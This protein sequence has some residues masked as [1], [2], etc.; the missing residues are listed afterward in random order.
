M[1]FFLRRGYAPPPLL[2]EIEVGRRIKLNESGVPAE[3]YVSKHDYESGLN[4]LGRTLLVR[5]N[6]PK[7]GLY[8][9][10]GNNGFRNGTLWAWLNNTY[11]STLDADVQAAI[12]TTKHYIRGYSDSGDLYSGADESAIFQLSASELGITGY[13]GTALP[14]ASILQEVAL[15]GSSSGTFQ[16]TTTTM[17]N[18]LRVLVVAKDGVTTSARCDVEEHLYRPTFTLPADFVV[19]KDMLV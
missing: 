15:D 18:S 4:G 12:G 6:G 1:G 7:T 9:T 5:K 3:F 11:L 8:N 19:S 2:G 13:G 14:I 10:S 17:K 16:W